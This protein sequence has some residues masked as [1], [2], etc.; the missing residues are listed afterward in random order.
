MTTRW[1]EKWRGSAPRKPFF[2][3][4]HLWDVHYDYAPPPPYDMLFDPHYEGTVTGRDYARSLEVHPGMDRRDL[5][6]VI[7]LYDGEI[8]YTDEHL[9][10]L[11]ERMPR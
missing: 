1:L 8:R 11:L 5:E 2:I 9:G 7:A 4:L 10:R 6:H 3:F